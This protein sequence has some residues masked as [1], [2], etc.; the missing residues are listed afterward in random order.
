MI[1][2]DLATETSLAV[3]KTVCIIIIKKKDMLSSEWGS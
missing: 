1:K 3:T 2:I